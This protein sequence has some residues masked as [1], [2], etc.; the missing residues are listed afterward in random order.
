MVSDLFVGDFGTAANKHFEGDPS[1]DVG[2]L[3]FKV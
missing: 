2:F 1:P 3:K